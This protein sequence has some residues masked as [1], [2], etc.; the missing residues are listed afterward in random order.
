MAEF[1]IH[2]FI[3]VCAVVH[4]RN[5]DDMGKSA[6]DRSISTVHAAG[7]RQRGVVLVDEVLKVAKNLWTL[8]RAL[9]WYLIAHAP[10]DEARVVAV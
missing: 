4:A 7:D 10:H 6:L 8:S 2:V 5:V 3:D 9:F 1:V